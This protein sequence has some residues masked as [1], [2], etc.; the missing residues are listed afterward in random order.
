[1]GTYSGYRVDVAQE[2]DV[3]VNDVIVNYYVDNVFIGELPDP[4]YNYYVYITEKNPIILKTAYEQGYV[5]YGDLLAIAK[6]ENTS[7]TE[8]NNSSNSSS[9]TSE[10][11]EELRTCYTVG[12]YSGYRV[13]MAQRILKDSDVNTVIVKYYVDDVFIGELSDPSYNYYVYITE[14][15]PIIL[16]TAYAE[17]YITHD[18]LLAI[19]EIENPKSVTD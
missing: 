14:K 2:K 7:N 19:A 12:T 9:N 6:K 15:D 17:G 5:T 11:E 13:D 3:N 8:S 1:V 10:T 4:S 16:K 18:D